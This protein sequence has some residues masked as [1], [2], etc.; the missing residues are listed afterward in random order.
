[1]NLLLLAPDIK[2]EIPFLPQTTEG[3]DRATERGLRTIIGELTFV[4]LRHIW[5]R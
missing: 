1:M 2:E 5:A 4:N 3:R